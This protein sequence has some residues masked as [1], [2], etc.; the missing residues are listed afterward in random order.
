MSRLRILQGNS[1][2]I[3]SLHLFSALLIC[4]IC[5]HGVES[6]CFQETSRPSSMKG[7]KQ[8]NPQKKKKKCI[9]VEY[10]LALKVNHNI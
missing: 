9:S 2:G 7:P 5:F 3:K 1:L 10:I 4:L 6:G 8:S